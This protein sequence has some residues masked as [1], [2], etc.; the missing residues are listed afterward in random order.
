MKKGDRYLMRLARRAHAPV[1]IRGPRHFP[2]RGLL[3]TPFLA[4]VVV[5]ASGCGSSSKTTT[6]A[7]PKTH[8][9][10][11][12]S[13]STTHASTSTAKK[14]GG[15]LSGKWSGQYSGAY[16][17]TFHLSWQQSG[18]NLGGTITLSA[19]PHTLGLHGTVN[20]NAIRF[21]TVGSVAITYSGTVSG[22]SMSGTYHTPN[23]G[24]PWSA[25]KTP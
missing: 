7:K 13:T 14:A 6:T 22:N 17:G 20:G 1:S 21:G 11:H 4:A 16:Q 3:V 12:A 10:T 23:G 9:A 2:P 19:P 18:S 25:N 8:A 15:G 24:G 5:M